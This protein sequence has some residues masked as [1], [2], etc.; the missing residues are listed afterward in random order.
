MTK[1]QQGDGLSPGQRS[2]CEKRVG[3]RVLQQGKTS[4]GMPNDEKSPFKNEGILAG[5]RGGESQGSSK[6]AG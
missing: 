1:K 4:Q 5:R 3:E 6:E 2:A